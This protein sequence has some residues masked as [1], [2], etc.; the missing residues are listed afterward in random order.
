MSKYVLQKE[1]QDFIAEYFFFVENTS[2]SVL[3]EIRMFQFSEIAEWVF[4]ERAMWEM[5]NGLPISQY[6]ISEVQE[7]VYSIIRKVNKERGKIYAENV[8]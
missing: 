6:T 5:N 2:N 1:L 3:V 4:K 7:I 8:R